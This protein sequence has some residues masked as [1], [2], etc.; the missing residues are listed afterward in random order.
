MRTRAKDV[1]SIRICPC[2]IESIYSSSGRSLSQ[3]VMRRPRLG[4]PRADVS[5]P[6]CVHSACSHSLSSHAAALRSPRRSARPRRRRKRRHRA[7]RPHNHRLWT[8]RQSRP[9]AT[10]SSTRS[11]ITTRRLPMHW[12]QRSCF[13]RTSDSW[14]RQ[15]WRRSCEASRPQCA[16]S[17]AHVER[18]A[19]LPVGDRR[20][21][22]RRG[23]RAHSGRGRP[24][25]D[26]TGRLAHA[27]LGTRRAD[28]EDRPLPVAE[29]GHRRRA[30]H[31]ERAL[32]SVDRVQ[33]DAEPA[34]GRRRERQNP[35]HCTRS[36]D[37]PGS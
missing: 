29:R 36:L 27:R 17:D 14:T 15:R 16:R 10:R 32:S 5:S 28:M 34:P 12:D 13:S 20:G 25:G 8:R 30:G 19:R 35:R 31:V 26:R 6:A 23:R 7:H 1:R 24:Q 2:A 3:S 18:R 11:T 9:R 33:A 22:C 37:G 21:V 4:D